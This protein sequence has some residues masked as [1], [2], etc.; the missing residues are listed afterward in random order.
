MKRKSGGGGKVPAVGVPIPAIEMKNEVKR[1]WRKL[2]W[3]FAT[4]ISFDFWKENEMEILKFFAICLLVANA[5]YDAG[6]C[7]WRLL[8]TR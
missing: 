6:K 4:L 8:N 5:G 3:K 2:K 1:I 7:V